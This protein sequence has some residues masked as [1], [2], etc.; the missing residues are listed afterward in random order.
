MKCPDCGHVNL[1]GE[2]DCASCHAPLSALATP[3]PKQGMQRRILEGKVRDLGFH[4][5]ANLTEDTDLEKA[6]R[7]MREKRV[8]CVLVTRGG[9]LAGILTERDLLLKS[10]PATAPSQRKVKDVMRADTECLQ[11]DEPLA[12]AFHKMT[13]NGSHHLPVRR[14]DGVLGVVSARDLL[15]YLCE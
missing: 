9:A 11:D 7:V 8:G 15:R 5:A 2:E 12:Y 1:D 6:V 14:S 4:E 10:D 3:Q 13:I